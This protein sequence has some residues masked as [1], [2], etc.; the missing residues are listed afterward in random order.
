MRTS[1]LVTIAI[2]VGISVGVV[3]LAALPT[4]LGF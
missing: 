1:V 2:A 4:L 3:I